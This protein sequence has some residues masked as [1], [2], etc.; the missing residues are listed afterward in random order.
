MQLLIDIDQTFTMKTQYGDLVGATKVEGSLDNELLYRNL[1]FEL[2][3]QPQF[4][5][6]ADQ[7]KAAPAGSAEQQRLKARQDELVAQRKAHLQEFFDQHPE[8]F[9]TKFKYAGQNP[10]LK[11]ILKPDGS[12]DLVAQVFH[13]RN[14]FWDNVDFSDERLLNTPVI[15]NKLKR[16]ITELTPQRADSINVATD[17]LMARVLDQPEYYKF[18]ANWIAVHY[19]P[20]STTLMDPQAIF[21]H[22]VR[23]Y[24]TKERAF[25]SDSSEIFALQQ[26]AYEMA[27][28]L[29]GQ[30][31]PDVIAPD[32]SGKLR[33]LYALKAPY[34]IVYMYNPTCE[35]CMVQTPQLVQFYRE[36]NNRGVDVFAI[37]LDTNDQE[38]KD[39]IAKVGMP[40][41]NNVFDPTNKSIY[42]KYFVDITPEVYVLNPE[43]TIIAKNINVNQIA[44]VIRRDQEGR[45]KG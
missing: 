14:E 37:A 29:V 13:Y 36:W 11:P 43:R 6:V 35:H 17:R 21:V 45:S 9:F 23:N 2:D 31:G 32:P 22:M 33:S 30:K 5:A 19:D 12:P 41:A 16:Y 44:E 25:W 27:A 10:D 40:W 24:F 28:S 26:R 3:I 4:Q 38:W 15:I 20:K 34:I 7:L 39:Y 18:F 42:A 8:A 1:Q